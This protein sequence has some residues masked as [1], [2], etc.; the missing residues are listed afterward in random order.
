MKSFPSFGFPYLFA[1]PSR[2]YYMSLRVFQ[3]TYSRIFISNHQL[4]FHHF[5]QLLG[6]RPYYESWLN[7]K[8]KLESRPIT[9][10]WIY[11]IGM[12]N[13]WRLES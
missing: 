2:L 5:L 9:N 11:Y 3:N 6:G 10:C 12:R 13:K 7:I 1:S 8:S 4:L